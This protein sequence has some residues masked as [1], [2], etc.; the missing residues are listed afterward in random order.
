MTLSMVCLVVFWQLLRQSGKK[1]SVQV[2]FIMY[3]LGG[4]GKKNEQR[5]AHSV[6][7]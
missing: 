4:V 6:S 3:I 7:K 1:H 2:I 5:I